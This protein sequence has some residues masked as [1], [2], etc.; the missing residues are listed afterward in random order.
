MTPS[1][2]A[3]S[4]MDAAVEL[5]AER[6][7][8]G[9]S[10]HD[11]QKASGHKNRSAINYHFGGKVELIETLIAE[12]VD[13]HDQLRRQ[14]LD[15]LGATPTLRE[16]LQAAVAP[17][18]DDLATR[19]RRLR[20]RMLA[21]LAVDERHMGFIQNTM[22]TSPGLARSTMSILG[23]LGSLPEPIRTERVVLATTFGLRTFA[24]QA[25]LLDSDAPDRPPLAPSA[26]TAHTV[27]LLEALL[28]APY[29]EPTEDQP[30]DRT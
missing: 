7:V 10:L 16:V 4:I 20:L 29:I 15:A 3:R 8:D 18:I 6:G 21:N 2:G 11:I 12:I 9:V 23:F 24:D 22:V 27:T 30:T 13:D 26:F 1:P 14:R 19:P 28:T 5:F 25:R 17:M